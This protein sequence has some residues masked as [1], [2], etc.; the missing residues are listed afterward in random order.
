MR[1]GRLEGLDLVAVGL[2][3]MI[4]RIEGLFGMRDG[5]VGMI[6]GLVPETSPGGAEHIC[7]SVRST[8]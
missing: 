8:S 2:I 4:E 3:G 1:R 6:V 7:L 5:G